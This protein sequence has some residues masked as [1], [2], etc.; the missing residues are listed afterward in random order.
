M[1]MGVDV[2]R[3]DVVLMFATKAAFLN[4]G[5]SEFGDQ[6]LGFYAI[7]LICNAF[8][9]HEPYEFPKLDEIFPIQFI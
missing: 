5:H 8:V 7:V 3:H 6:S 4:C 2:V 9:T 1:E